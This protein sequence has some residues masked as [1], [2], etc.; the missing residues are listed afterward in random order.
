MP[1][2]PYPQEPM[3]RGEIIAR[4]EGLEAR[5]GGRLDVIESKVTATLAQATLTNGRVNKADERLDALEDVERV[6]TAIAERTARRVG[7]VVGVVAGVA[8]TVVGGLLLW[9]LTG[10]AA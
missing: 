3:S 4:L 8:T 10:G 2:N 5:V 1:D 9:L 7:I 6:R